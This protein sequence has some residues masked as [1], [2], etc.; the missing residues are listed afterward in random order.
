MRRHPCR[1]TPS[2]ACRFC[3]GLCVSV[4][5][6][7][8]GGLLRTSVLTGAPSPAAHPGVP[9]ILSRPNR[10]PFVTRHR[11][12]ADTP[13]APNRYSVSRVPRERRFVC[14]C[15]SSSFSFPLFPCIPSKTRP[16]SAYFRA[17]QRRN[18]ESHLAVHIPVPRLRDG[19]LSVS[20]RLACADSWRPRFSRSD[21]I[22][23]HRK[24]QS[25]RLQERYFN[26]ETAPRPLCPP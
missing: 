6:L 17:A 22:L 2:P 8:R 10:A 21:S 3:T 16:H 23:L 18:A 11:L 26:F 4:N 12:F 15:A 5:L 9:F 20:S 13:P 25:D 14:P 1:V 19:S 24:L 7:C